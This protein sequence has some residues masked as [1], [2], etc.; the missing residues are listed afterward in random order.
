M[1][2]DEKIT[3][4]D[5]IAPQPLECGACMAAQENEMTPDQ[6]Y[7][8]GAVEMHL[9]GEEKIFA[10]FCLKHTQYAQGFLA[11]IRKHTKGKAK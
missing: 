4:P 2:G 1:A 5:F 10:T 6:A 3:L 11:E 8:I 7:V 9:G